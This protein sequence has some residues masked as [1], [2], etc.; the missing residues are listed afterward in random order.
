LDHLEAEYHDTKTQKYE[1]EA[2][3]QNGNKIQIESL[4]NTRPLRVLWIVQD[5]DILPGLELGWIAVQFFRHF[6]RLP[7]D[8][9]ELEHGRI[10]D[11]I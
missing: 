7:G 6:N 5:I 1:P 2:A 9:A 10:A 8:R 4:V 11:T 3:E